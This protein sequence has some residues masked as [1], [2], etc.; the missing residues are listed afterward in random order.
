MHYI[1]DDSSVPSTLFEGNVIFVYT[2]ENFIS[3]VIL[4]FN[5]II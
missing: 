1:N 2:N 3:T 4:K 5:I